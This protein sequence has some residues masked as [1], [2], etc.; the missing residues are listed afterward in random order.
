MEKTIFSS[1]IDKNLQKRVK[2]YCQKT[3]QKI[4]GF[5]EKA[6][7]EALENRIAKVAK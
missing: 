3:N 1:R 4:Q 2:D 7:K 5:L 6:L